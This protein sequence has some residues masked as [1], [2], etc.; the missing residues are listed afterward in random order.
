[1]AALRP[2]TTPQ[3][4]RRRDPHGDRTPIARKGAS[5]HVF[6]S[7]LLSEA[8]EQQTATS[9][10]LRVISNSPTDV[11]PVFDAIA[12]TAARLCESFDAAIYRPDG[13][14]LVLVAHHGAIPLGPIGDFS[15]PF[16]RGTVAGQSM[17]SGRT[18]HVADVQTEGDEFPQSSQSARLR[19]TVRR[20][21]GRA[22]EDELLGNARS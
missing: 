19:L 9:E 13:D 11:W 3:G 6:V 15:I 5:R 4:N 20:V 1:V 12:E 8:L 18:V 21:P 16:V 10:I 2:I 17:F 22:H 7:T 14:R